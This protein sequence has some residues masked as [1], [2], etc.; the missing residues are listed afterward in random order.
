[1]IDKTKESEAAIQ[2]KILLA[3][4]RDG[5]VLFRQNTAT[6][7]V[8]NAQKFHRAETVL[9]GHG[10]VLIRNARVLHAGLCVG[11]P[12]IVGWQPVKITAD[13]VGTTLAVF[14]GLEVKSA[15][16]R[17]TPEQRN[18]LDRL[19]QAGGVASV[20]RSPADAALALAGGATG[21]GPPIPIAG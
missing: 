8:G 3:C 14:V 16:G 9:V 15:T 4:G 7:Y 20:V 12:D 19:A 13:M 18:F 17:P 11:S 1:V 10:D 6:G 21:Y 2:A 5:T